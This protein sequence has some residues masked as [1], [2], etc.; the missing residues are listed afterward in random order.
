MV[1]VLV[2]IL[3]LL[4]CAMANAQPLN[5]PTAPRQPV[6]QVETKTQV[7]VAKPRLQ[8]ILVQND[9]R[10]A[11]INNQNVGVGDRV[12]GYRVTRITANYVLLQGKG[13]TIRLSL[14]NADFIK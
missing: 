6:K 11:V 9:H 5:D 13:G 4:G 12:D 3:T 8:S 2:W 7:V 1:N 10:S 14:F